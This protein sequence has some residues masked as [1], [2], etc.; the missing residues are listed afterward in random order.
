MDFLHVHYEARAEEGEG[1]R[2]T[3]GP[4]HGVGDASKR[5]THERG[6]HEDKGTHSGRVDLLE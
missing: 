3:R 4:G 6:G 2:Q 1:G 5:N